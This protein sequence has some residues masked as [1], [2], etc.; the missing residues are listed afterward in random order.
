MTLKLK[1][2]GCPGTPPREQIEE[3]PVNKTAL[4]EVLRREKPVP[5]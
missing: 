1:C 5:L 4:A 2:K 3:R